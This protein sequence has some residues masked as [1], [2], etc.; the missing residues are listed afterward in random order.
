MDKSWY[1]SKT[2]QGAAVF[3]ITGFLVQS[4]FMP[5]SL[6]T[7]LVTWV[8]GLWTVYGARVALG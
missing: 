7:E 4:G 8:S 5:E 3:A 6:V 2:V 1:Q